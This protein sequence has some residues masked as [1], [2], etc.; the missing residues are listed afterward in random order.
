MK[1]GLQH[2]LLCDTR[3]GA[4]LLFDCDD[5]SSQ[6]LIKFDEITQVSLE[7]K[8][9]GSNEEKILEIE[10]EATDKVDELDR[11]YE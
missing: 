3:L 1:C 11:I 6:I 4:C 7:D 5:Y 9:F 10:A 8:S 2:G